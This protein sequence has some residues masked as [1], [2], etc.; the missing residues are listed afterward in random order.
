MTKY[1]NNPNPKEWASDLSRNKY[2]DWKFPSVSDGLGVRG[3]LFVSG[4]PF[5]CLNCFNSSIW[6]F[7]NGKDFTKDVE[8]KIISDLSLSYVKGLTLLG[9]EPFL[10]TNILIPLVKRVRRELPT[11]DIWSW[12]G[13]TWEELLLDTDDKL[14]LLSNIDVLVDGRFDQRYVDGNHPFRGSA[15]QRIIDVQESLK[16]NKLVLHESN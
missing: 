2:V 1:Y 9:G 6:N 16:H 8:D 3:S 4:C 10:S 5:H 15:N 14:E 12:T 7:D 11:K 13:Y